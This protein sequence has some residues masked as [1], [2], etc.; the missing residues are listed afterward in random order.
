M[1]MKQVGKNAVHQ[2]VLRPGHDVL[3]APYKRM[4]QY[5]GLPSSRRGVGGARAHHETAREQKKR[6]SSQVCYYPCAEEMK[7]SV[8][9]SVEGRTGS[10]RTWLPHSA[11]YHKTLCLLRP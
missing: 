3:K 1:L 4:R 11:S 2:N 10:G 7:K 8:E 5:P 6:F 9:V